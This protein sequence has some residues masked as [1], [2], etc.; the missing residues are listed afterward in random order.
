VRQF[1]IAVQ[2]FVRDKRERR[3]EE[4]GAG[5]RRCRSTGE[6]PPKSASAGHGMAWHGIEQA[7]Q[8][9]HDGGDV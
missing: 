4:L 6:M 2:D 5:L 7:V 8:M 9:P 1:P 3:S